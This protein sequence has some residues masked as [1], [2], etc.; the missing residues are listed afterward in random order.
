MVIK[1]LNR[2]ALILLTAAAIIA[3]PFYQLWQEVKWAW[4]N[5]TWT[6]EVRGA[7]TGTWPAFIRDFKRGRLI[8]SKEDRE[9]RHQAAMDDL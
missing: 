7:L 2:I 1:F 4:G 5:W 9:K 6:R 8:E 3:L